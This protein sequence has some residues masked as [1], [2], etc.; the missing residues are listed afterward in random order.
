MF[1]QSVAETLQSQQNYVLW[2][3]YCSLYAQAV[4]W[5]ARFVKLNTF[6]LYE[7]PLKLHFLTQI[8]Q[9]LFIH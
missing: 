1:G 7:A 2:A 9:Q 3:V 4:V 5:R 6:Q 8:G